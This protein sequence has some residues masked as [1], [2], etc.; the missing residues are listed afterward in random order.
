MVALGPPEGEGLAARIVAV[1]ASVVRCDLPGSVA[2]QSTPR[3]SNC[4]FTLG[5]VAPDA[6]LDDVM[7]RVRR[8]LAVKLAALSQTMIARLIREYDHDNRLEGFLRIMQAV[9]TD[10]M[11]WVLD[12]KLSRFLT[13]VLDDDLG[14]LLGIKPPLVR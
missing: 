7:E 4:G 2:P 5:A 3:C 9:Q 6:E 11:V 10:A 12:E 1:A 13:H 14:D 8:G